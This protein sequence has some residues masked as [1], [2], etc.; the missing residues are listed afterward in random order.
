MRQYV[1]VAVCVSVRV[2]LC[3]YLTSRLAWCVVR[4]LGLEPG[5][6]LEI[7]WIDVLASAWI[8]VDVLKMQCS[9]LLGWLC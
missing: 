7:S 9:D 6:N 4:G 1:C 8:C 3:V 5:S 2:C